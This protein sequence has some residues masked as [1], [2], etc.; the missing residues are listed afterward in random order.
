MGVRFD[1]M[2]RHHNLCLGGGRSEVGREGVEETESAYHGCIGKR[3]NL[4][5]IGL[6]MRS[7]YESTQVRSRPGPEGGRMQEEETGRYKGTTQQES[8]YD[9]EV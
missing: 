3:S 8:R 7:I 6:E 9:G 2:S 5:Y 4:E 1:L